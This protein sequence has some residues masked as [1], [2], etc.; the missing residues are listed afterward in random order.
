MLREIKY[1]IF[2][3]IILLFLFLNFKYY[4]SDLNQKKTYRSLNKIDDK[5]EI[6]SNNLPTLEDD[7]KN[8]IEFV[9][10]SKNKKKKFKFWKLLETN[11]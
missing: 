1:F 11:E 5:I 7:T 2:L 8:I 3:L 9:E 10:Q 4:F 6:F